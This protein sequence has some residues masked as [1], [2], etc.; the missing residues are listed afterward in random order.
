MDLRGVKV[1]I[2]GGTSGIGLATVE[3][4]LREE[5]S[6][7]V[8]AR[9][10]NKLVALDN[11]HDLAGIY[12]CDLSNSKALITLGEQLVNDH[13]DL[14]V[15]INNAGI[16]NNIM[17]DS[18]ESTTHKIEYEMQTNFLAPLLLIRTLLPV[19]K[20]QQEAVILNVTTGLALVPKTNSAVYCGTKG[21]L[22]IFTQALRNQLPESNVRIIEILPPVVETPMTLGRGSNKLHPDKVAAAILS[23][24][25]G[26][27]NEVYVSKTK[28]LYWLARLSPAIARNMMRRLG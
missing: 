4:L 13:P 3:A 16:Q 2:T 15:L 21:G 9:D 8:V 6:V 22:R 17:F 19:L 18:D 20:K 10:K 11:K 14:Q 7:I 26:R 24:I 25:K 23:S 12:S 27:A 28:L 1:L 5:A